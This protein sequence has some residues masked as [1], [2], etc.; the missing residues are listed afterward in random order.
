MLRTASASC[1]ARSVRSPLPAAIA[2]ILFKVSSALPIHFAPRTAL[3]GA[4]EH[5]QDHRDLPG[6][7]NGVLH[8][9]REQRFVRVSATGNLLPQFFRG[10]IADARF[11][12]VAAPVP[13]GDE[14]FP[15]NW[16]LGPFLFRLPTWHRSAF[17]GLSDPFIPKQQMLEKRRNGMRAWNRWRDGIFRGRFGDQLCERRSVPRS[18]NRHGVVRIGDLLNLGH[19][20]HPFGLCSK[21]LISIAKTEARELKS[22]QN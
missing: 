15:G 22:P 21:P 1:L 4:R 7:I 8:D 9:T 11:E 13:P 6:M 14:F 19:F 5:A 20:W 16:R 3:F 2:R 10:K 12:P 17:A 18:F